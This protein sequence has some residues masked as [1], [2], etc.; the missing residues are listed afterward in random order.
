MTQFFLYGHCLSARF[1]VTV[2]VALLL[3]TFATYPGTQAIKFAIS[4]S[5]SLIKSTAH[6]TVLMKDC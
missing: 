2:A 6:Q 4:I 5:L 3:L 1:G